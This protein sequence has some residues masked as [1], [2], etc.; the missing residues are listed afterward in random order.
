M[1][2]DEFG[3]IQGV[4][5]LHDVLVAVVGDITE[6]GAGAEP[7]QAIRRP[8][9]SWLLDG[10]LPAGDFRD[11]FKLDSLPDEDDGTYETLAGFISMLL[12]HIPQVADRVEW[13]GFRFE[14]VDMDGRRIDKVLV[15]PPPGV[16][17]GE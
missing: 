7:A 4:V 17:T 14:I 16:E 3:S 8:D 5:T 9:G 10:M 2:V 15:T 6:P 1:V 12:G 13:G 11:L